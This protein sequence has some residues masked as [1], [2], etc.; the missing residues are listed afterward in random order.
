MFAAVLPE[1]MGNNG[2]GRRLPGGQ[3]KDLPEKAAAV[4]FSM[5]WRRQSCQRGQP[6]GG[7]ALAELAG[8]RQ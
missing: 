6:A 4:A 7:S 5:A 1:Q 3:G 8:F 2:C